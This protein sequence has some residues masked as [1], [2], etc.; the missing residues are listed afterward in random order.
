VK[1]VEAGGERIALC[2]TAEGYFA[3]ADICSHDGGALDQG[4]LL[5]D[6]IECPRHG[7]QFDVKSG[8]ALTLPAVRPIR[9]YETR[10]VNGAVEVEVA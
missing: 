2:H 3:V 6:R 10:V 4:E 8:K 9:A 1:V 7:A 5:G